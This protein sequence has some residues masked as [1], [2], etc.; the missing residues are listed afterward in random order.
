MADD[1]IV[2][3]VFWYNEKYRYN[4][5]NEIEKFLIFN[6]I[7]M[8]NTIET[9]G[10]SNDLEKQQK[11]NDSIA[12]IY[13]HVSQFLIGSIGDDWEDIKEEDVD[14]K[15]D[16]EM[17]NQLKQAKKHIESLQLLLPQEQLEEMNQLLNKISSINEST[18]KDNNMMDEIGKLVDKVNGLKSSV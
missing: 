15:Y 5:L 10:Y 6:L 17:I 16:K 7:N 14:D 4:L 3:V 18:K 2:F 1:R 8:K 9:F 13:H 12:M 11:I